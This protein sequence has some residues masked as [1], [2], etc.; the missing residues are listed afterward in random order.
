[1]FLGGIFDTGKNEN[2]LLMMNK[3]RRRVET[4]NSR[5]NRAS[6]LALASTA[7]QRLILLVDLMLGK[8][9]GG[10]RPTGDEKCAT[11]ASES[12]G[13]SIPRQ[14][15]QSIAAVTKVRAV[16]FHRVYDHQR[17]VNHQARE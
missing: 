6:A 8:E 17:L 14:L 1:M 15:P 7:A 2:V 12:D 13:S 3:E 5:I 4:E 10:Q 11:I 9:V 16:H